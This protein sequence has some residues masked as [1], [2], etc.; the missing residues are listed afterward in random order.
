MTEG[1]L[2]EGKI[3]VGVTSG[4]ST[5]DAQAFG[6]DTGAGQAAGDSFSGKGALQLL[7]AAPNVELCHV[8]HA[9]RYPTACGQ[10]I[11]NTCVSRSDLCARSTGHSEVPHATYRPSAPIRGLG[12]SRCFCF[13]ATGFVSENMARRVLP[14]LSHTRRVPSEVRPELAWEDFRFGP[15]AHRCCAFTT[16]PN[17]LLGT[18]VGPP[19]QIRACGADLRPNPRLPRL[20]VSR[21]TVGGRPS[22]C[23]NVFVAPVS[24]HSCAGLVILECGVGG[25]LGSPST[26]PHRGP[27]KAQ[28]SAAP[29]PRR[30]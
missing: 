24:L 30:C 1:F 11:V 26:R 4:A 23:D 15:M 16:E 21:L 13:V 28:R 6:S 27:F 20:A 8:R 17:I 7:Q 22:C 9:A 29:P 25:L 2:P 19:Q 3:T 10:R 5:P 12:P 18:F 14:Q